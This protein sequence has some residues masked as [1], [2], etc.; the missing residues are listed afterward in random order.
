MLLLIS[1]YS[2]PCYAESG[3]LEQ[4]YP[5]ESPGGMLPTPWHKLTWVIVMASH[6]WAS[7]PGHGGSGQEGLASGRVWW[8]GPRLHL[9]GVRH[10]RHHQCL[11][12]E[13]SVLCTCSTSARATI[14]WP[15]ITL[16]FMFITHTIPNWVNSQ[17]LW[18]VSSWRSQVK[19]WYQDGT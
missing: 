3:V 1:W 5:S 8:S 17:L 12:Q 2:R 16:L 19:A 4:R 7:H 18:F 6:R 13:V 10:R 9:P 15:F 14:H 11:Q